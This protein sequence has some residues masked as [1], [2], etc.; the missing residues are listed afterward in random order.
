VAR[1][2]LLL[3]GV[4][5]GGRTVVRMAD[6]RELLTA[7]GYGEVGTLL[8][9][10]NVALDAGDAAPEAV[11]DDIRARLA[12]HAGR[13]FG[14]L[15]RTPGELDAILGADPLGDLRTDGARHAVAF[16]DAAPDVSALEDRDWGAERFAVAGREVHLHLPGGLGRSPLMVA[17]DRAKVARVVTVRNWN[18]VVRLA[19]LVRA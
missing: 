6:L 19:E 4:N 18:T 15:A 3:R 9:S 1:L 8:Q 13:E 7:A 16:C 11:A 2:A 10:G 17:L 12:A 14:V 5:V